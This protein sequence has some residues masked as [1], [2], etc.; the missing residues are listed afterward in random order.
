V[1][2]KS[3]SAPP[4]GRG[5]IDWDLRVP[6]PMVAL[7]FG[8][9]LAGGAGLLTNYSIY[10]LNL[11]VFLLAGLAIVSGLVGLQAFYNQE[12]HRLANGP[13]SPHL[14]VYRQSPC[15]IAPPLVEDLARFLSASKQQIQEKQWDA[16]WPAYQLHTELAE[17]LTNEGNFVEAF[18]EHCQALNVLAETVQNQRPKGE[19]FQP[20]WDKR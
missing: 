19:V 20:I 16:D 5:G 3:A 12:K 13:E 15:R 6:W 11:A 9:V 1:R 8:V 4:R 18:R 14:Q 17:K 10:P 2:E 7:L